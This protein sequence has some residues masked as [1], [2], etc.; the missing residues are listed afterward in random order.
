M[1]VNVENLEKNLVKL[2]VEV[3]VEDLEKGINKVYL[4]ARNQIALPGFRKGKAPRKMIEQAYG[5][6]VFM[7]D[8]INE[9]VP[10]AYEAACE[11]SKLEIVSQPEIAYEQVEVGKPVIF[12]ATVAIKPEVALGEYK[13]LSVETETAEVTE[14]D[15]LAELAKEQDKNSTTITIED[16]AV[17]DGDMV[18]LDFEGF[19]EG[20]AFEGGKGENF[21]LT[22]GSHSFIDTFEEQ[23][24]GTAI[25]EEKEVNVTFP[26]EYHVEELAGKPALFKCVINGIKA[27]E[28]PAL[29][30]E[31]AGEVSDFE[32][33]E[34]YKADIRAKLEEAKA[35]TAKTAKEDALVD[36]AVENA[37]MELPDLMIASQARTMVQEFSQRLQAQ[38]LSMEQYMQYTG[39]TMDQMIEEMKG[40][41]TKR[42][43]TRLVLE[44]VAKQEGIE[45]SEEDI[46]KEIEEMAK[47]Y[48]MEVDQ[49]KSFITE[50]QKEQMRENIAVQKALD[51]LYETAK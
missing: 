19:V 18:E 11:E 7:E 21:P 8:A 45:A 49:I 6:D 42:I 1:S 27:K 35:K 41:A 47:G 31:F 44:A 12:T 29:D 16:R 13:G 22:I 23:L 39:Q 24:V 5:A 37:S 3:P 26:E 15:I 48:G 2:T 38:G 25:G 30:D 36:K 10:E 17:T 50:E 28:L 33:L 51:L 43:E 34:E 46:E 14:E 32:T 20:E 9:L 4:K 40:Q